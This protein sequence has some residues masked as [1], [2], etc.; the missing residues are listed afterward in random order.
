VHAR[1]TRPA[2]RITFSAAGHSSRKA[3]HRDGQLI[4]Q[5]AGHLCVPVRTS[6]TGSSIA[7]TGPR[8]DG[9]QLRA[10]AMVGALQFRQVLLQGHPDTSAAQATGDLAL[11]SATVRARFNHL[12]CSKPAWQHQLLTSQGATPPAGAEIVSCARNDSTKYVLSAAKKMPDHDIANVGA[13]PAGHGPGWQVQVVFDRA[14]K[15]AFAGI[16]GALFNRYHGTP[17][18]PLGELAMVLGETTLASPLTAGP[19]TQGVAIISQTP[20][21]FPAQAAQQIAA[22]LMS[23]ALPAALTVKSVRNLAATG[24]A[25]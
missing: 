5:R 3:L 10:L 7:L 6:V 19:V 4:A 12:N 17:G 25:G 16:T 24:R 23:G 9:P 2:T 1:V 22:V 8:A 15:A 20:A 13:G 21:G 11:V 18:S 14:G